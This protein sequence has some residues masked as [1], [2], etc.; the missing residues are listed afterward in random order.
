MAN[1]IK[2]FAHYR[3]CRILFSAVVKLPCVWK[4]TLSHIVW[5]RLH[6]TVSWEGSCAH[7]LI[8]SVGCARWNRNWTNFHGDSL[9]MSTRTHASV[10]GLQVKV[11]VSG[12]TPSLVPLKGRR[13]GTEPFTHTCARLLQT[14]R[15][16]AKNA[17]RRTGTL[18]TRAL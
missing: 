3:V 10:C 5:V 8:R 13:A 14:D 6:E 18:H 16:R 7:E 17:N 4:Q 9:R 2:A 1:R 15:T 12:A 11:F